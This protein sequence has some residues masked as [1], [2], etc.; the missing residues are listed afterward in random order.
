[1]ARTYQ[2]ILH[3]KLEALRTT[4]QALGS[5]SPMHDKVGAAKFGIDQLK[6][7]AT[8]DEFKKVLQKHLG[9]P[10]ADALMETAQSER[11]ESLKRPF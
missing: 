7:T 8:P 6:P 5:V 4:A 3:A 11:S 2:S 9:T 1:M 10:L